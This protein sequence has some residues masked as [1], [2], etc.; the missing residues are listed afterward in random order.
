MCRNLCGKTICLPANT[1]FLNK[2]KKTKIPKNI[3]K[4]K[5]KLKKK[6]DLLIINN[7]DTNMIA[8]KE[9]YLANIPAITLTEKLDISKIKSNYTSTG[10]YNFFAE[11]AENTNFFLLFLKTVILRA[12]K[13]NKKLGR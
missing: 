13:W 2:N 8:F 12:K 3:F 6:V 9:S 10:N 1:G 5:T 11:K 4:L 7:L